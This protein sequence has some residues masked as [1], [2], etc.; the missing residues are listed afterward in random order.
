VGI[1]LIFLPVGTPVGLSPLSGKKLSVGKGEWLFLTSSVF[2]GIRRIP[3]PKR[4]GPSTSIF[5]PPWRGLFA[6]IRKAPFFYLLFP[7]G[8][9][10]RCF[11][12]SFSFRYGPPPFLFILDQGGGLTFLRRGG[13]FFSRPPFF[14]LIYQKSFLPSPL[15]PGRLTPSLPTNCQ[16]GG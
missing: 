8:F 5:P 3:P 6:L 7:P 2:Y 10:Y 15:S 1:F 9:R 4:T 14:Q 12:F 16:R 13:F 11:P